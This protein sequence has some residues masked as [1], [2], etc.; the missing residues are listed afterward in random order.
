MNGLSVEKPVLN[1]DLCDVTPAPSM[2]NVLDRGFGDAEASRDFRKANASSDHSSCLPDIVICH[3]GIRDVH[4]SFPET[5]R[6]EP[7]LCDH[8]GGVLFR[9]SN[10]QVIGSH[11]RR[12]VAVV[13]DL[14]SVWDLSAKHLPTKAV[15]LH[16]YEAAVSLL[17]SASCPDPATIGLGNKGPEPFFDRTADTSHR[18][19]VDSALALG[20]VGHAQAMAVVPVPATRECTGTHKRNVSTVSRG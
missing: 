13:T 19:Q 16:S 1:A 5:G 6:D 18:P 4:S 17:V 9:R 2:G 3:L 20:I 10:E 7:A 12:I 11:T 8:V 14:E 15:R